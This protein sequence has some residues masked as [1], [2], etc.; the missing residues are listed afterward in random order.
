[1]TTYLMYLIDIIYYS[2][3]FDKRFTN[4]RQIY[5]IFIGRHLYN[6]YYLIFN[7]IIQ[8]DI[9]NIIYK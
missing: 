9:I 2:L 4:N 3:H 1:M 6:Y 5:I 7:V 8:D